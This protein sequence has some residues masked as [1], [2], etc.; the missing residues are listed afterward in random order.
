M[1]GEYNFFSLLLILP[2]SIIL[3]ATPASNEISI[4]K[5]S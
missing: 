2:P 4:K 5:K 1:Q 3:V